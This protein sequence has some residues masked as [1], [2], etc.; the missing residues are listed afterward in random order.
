MKRNA[1]KTPAEM[2]KAANLSVCVSGTGDAFVRDSATD[3]HLFTMPLTGWGFGG[4]GD[5][6]DRRLT[7]EEAE[8]IIARAGR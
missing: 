3:R 7:R 6:T 5:G 1:I 2:I 8:T 4:V